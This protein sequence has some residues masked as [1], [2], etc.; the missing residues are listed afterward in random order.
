MHQSFVFP[1]P[2][3]CVFT[4]RKLSPSLI[5]VFPSNNSQM[6]FHIV[7]NRLRGAGTFS[8]DFTTNLTPQCLAFRG[9][10]KTEKIPRPQGGGVDT[11]DWCIIY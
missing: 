11:N 6:L 4:C 7:V 9:A 1:A 2:L 5:F 8:K 10:L 3:I